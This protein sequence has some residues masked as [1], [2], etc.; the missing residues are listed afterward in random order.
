MVDS[1]LDRRRVFLNKR[2]EEFYIPLIREFSGEHP[3]TQERWD[4]V[5]EIMTSKRHLCGS[6][7]AARLPQHFEAT[8]ERAPHYERYYLFT[9]DDVN[10]WRKIADTLWEEY[11]DTL[12]EYYKLVGVEEY[13][14]PEKPEW[15]FK[16]SIRGKI[17]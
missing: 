1:Y 7:V 3:K 17:Y 11:I 13:T 12:K 6:K 16:K 14:L 15:A 9:E 8:I 4:T 5:E 10:K 2:L